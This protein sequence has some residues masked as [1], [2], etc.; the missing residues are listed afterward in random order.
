MP[1]QKRRRPRGHIRELPSGS[2]QVIVYAGTDPLTKKDRYIRET[3]KTYGAA[4]VA[5]TRLQ[6]QVDQNRHPKTDITLGQAI[7]RW[8]DV[9]TLEDT[10]RDRYEDLVRLYIQPVLGGFPAAKLDAE[11]LESFYARLQRCRDLCGGRRR[12]GHECRP[13][14]GSTVRKVHYVISAALEQAVRWRH[15]GVNPA[16]LAIAPSPNHTEPDPPSAEE[17]AAVIGAA[18]SDPDWGLLLWVIMV[19][20]MRRGEI[21]ALRW[22]HV[23]FAADTVIVQR[24][25]AEPKSGVKEKQT[26]DA[27]AAAHRDRCADGGPAARA[28]RAMGAALSPA[29]LCVPRRHVRVFSPAPDGSSPY[30]P[31]SLSHR[32]RR[33]AIRLGLRSTRLHSLRHYSATELIAAGVDVRTVAGRLGHGSGGATTLKVYAAWVDEAD[34]RAAT[35]MAGIMPVPAAAPRPPRGPYEVIAAELREQIETGRL[36]AGDQLPTVAELAARHGV[37]AGTAHRAIDVLRSEG[38]VDASRGRRSVVV[39]PAD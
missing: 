39:F 3:L 31:R 6:G 23:E 1:A 9:A 21:S 12:A 8:L 27:P 7:S 16:A 17:A 18:W 28:S 4:E 32:Y 35:T 38:L 24:A 36:R 13:L 19:T 37:A 26:K 33:L 25:N 20:G 29:R 34:R 30:G 11:L 10:T 2:F 5:L 14:S 22:R 15:L